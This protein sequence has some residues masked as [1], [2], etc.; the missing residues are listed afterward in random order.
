MG[1]AKDLKDEEK[2][3]II[4]ETAK[5]TFCASVA[6][7]LDRHVMA[8]QRF[9][10]YPSNRKHRSDKGK[11]KA[12]NGRDIRNIKRQ[13]FKSPGSTSKKIFE[14][15]GLN[16]IP[17]KTRNRILGSIATVKSPQKKPPI[18]KR[19]MQLRVNWARSYMTQDMK[20]VLFTDETRATLDGPDEWSKGWFG[21]GGKLHHRVRRHQGGSGVM[22]WAGIINGELVGPT[23]V[24]DGVKINSANYCP[25]LDDC[26]VPWLDD[27][28][29]GLRKK[30]IFMQDNTPSHSARA[31]KEYLAA[32]GFKNK[33]LMMFT[34]NSPDLNPIENFWPIIKR[35]IY[36]D[37]KQFASKQEL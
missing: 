30:L 25:L 5:G 13:V 12:V 36:A 1:R 29:L 11:M 8:V 17:K 18:T 20:I 31:M 23:M 27:Q 9:L 6:G 21:F 16:Q 14:N 3:I 32:L 15:S 26:L 22:L 4:K 19:H 2:Q 34:P 33:N 28:T 37:G 35:K 24:H 10:K 7:I